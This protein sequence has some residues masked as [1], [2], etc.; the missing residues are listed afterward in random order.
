MALDFRFYNTRTRAVAD[1]VPQRPGHVSLYSCGPTVY[2]YAHIG[3]LRAYV[4]VDVLKRALQWGGYQVRHVMNLT[5]VG[6][7]TDDADSGDDKMEL[8]ARRSGRDIWD[9]S[10]MYATAFFEHAADLAI[11]PPDVVCRAT[12]HI[13]Q[14]IALV[15]Q[16]EAQGAAYRADDG[17]YLDTNRVPGYADFAK[18][19]LHGQ[20]AGVRVKVVAG[21][22]NPH[23]FALWKFADPE[24]NRLMEWDSPWGRGFPGWHLE[25]SAMATHYLGK[26]F[27]IHT[28]G[29]DHIPVH[30]TNE[31]AQMKAATGCESWVNVWMHNNFLVLDKNDGSDGDK[32]S[33]SSGDFLT[34]DTLRGWAHQPLAYRYL[35]LRTHYRK[36][37]KFSRTNLEHA[38]ASLLRLWQNIAQ[39]QQQS[40]SQASGDADPS[41]LQ[42]HRDAFA[43]AICDDLNTAKGLAEVFGAVRNPELPAAAVVRF[44]ADADRVLGL[45]LLAGPVGGDRGGQIDHEAIDKLVQKRNQARANKDFAAADAI[46]DA[47]LAVGIQI[48]DGPDGT[49]WMLS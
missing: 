48:K 46:R 21:K 32:M 7:L 9:L 27:D 4:F 30:H 16:I 5:D 1:F 43:D 26:N 45:R 34:L 10:R 8:A 29:I 14:Q 37:V 41:A 3:N 35:L 39:R 42:S 33:K 23:D 49:R 13:D 40:A 19:D 22:R 24:K 18:L 17:I 25:C 28:G 47:L 36:E 2:N 44:V 31:I 6:H 38:E 11:L 12:D 15:Q 20:Q